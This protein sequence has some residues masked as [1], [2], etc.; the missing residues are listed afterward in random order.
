MDFGRI[1]GR[2]WQITW[3]FKILWLFGFLAAL[4]FNSP[5]SSSYRYDTLPPKLAGQVEQ[6]IFGPFFAPVIAG[7]LVAFFLIGIVFAI[8]KVIGRTGL[9]DQI[10]AAEQGIRPTGRAGWAAFRRYGWRMFWISFFSGLPGFLIFMVAIVPLLWATVS[11]LPELRSFSF[12]NFNP[13]PT[14]FLLGLAWFFP[15]CCLGVFVCAFFSLL[16]TLGERVCVIEDQGIWESIKGGWLM[17]WG[18]LGSVF[19]MWLLIFVINFAV[20]GLIVIPAILIS[21][22]FFVPLLL[23]TQILNGDFSIIGLTSLICLGGVIWIWGVSIAS[24]A[25]TFYSCCWTLIYRQL[26]GRE[27]GG[28][29]AE[30]C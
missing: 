2:A 21:L 27:F 4:Y 17:L 19:L 25:E 3:K 20:I 14:G 24:I 7:V 26:T 29:L 1:I 6:F 10:N 9:V 22:L 11:F 8:L 28:D 12:Y 18:Q 5:S 30:C 13:D 23:S 16:R 15:V